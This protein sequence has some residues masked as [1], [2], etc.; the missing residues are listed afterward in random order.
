MWG[1]MGSGLYQNCIWTTRQW[2]QQYETINGSL[3]YLVTEEIPEQNI[4]NRRTLLG[5]WHFDWTKLTH[6]QL[7]NVFNKIGL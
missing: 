2:A 1:P 4:V 5:L 7:N 6:T 3:Q